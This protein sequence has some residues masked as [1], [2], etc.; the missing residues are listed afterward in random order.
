MAGLS[1]IIIINHIVIYSILFIQ[2]Y[3]SGNG[4]TGSAILA[5]GNEADRQ[6]EREEG[7]GS[8]SMNSEGG[9]ASIDFLGWFIP[10]KSVA[11]TSYSIKSSSMTTW[12]IAAMDRSGWISRK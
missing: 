11:E 4:E 2:R 12:V 6:K 7:R 10:P 8:S 1:N 3:V 5:G 9:F